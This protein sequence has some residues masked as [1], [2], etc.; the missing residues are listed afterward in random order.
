MSWDLMVV[1]F[2]G[3]MLYLPKKNEFARRLWMFKWM[4]TT[5]TNL[6][7]ERRVDVLMDKRSPRVFGFHPHGVHCVAA[8]LISTEPAT[9][10]IRVACTYF[11]FWV[12]V[13][14]EFCGW[15]NA[16]SCEGD[17]IKSNL[18]K[19]TP[20]IIYPGGINEVPGAHYM[21]EPEY[22][23]A[24]GGD[25][26]YYVY[27]RRRG[28]IR[29][30]MEQGV[31]IVPCWVD[32]EYDL[33]T[34]YHP[35]PRIQRWCYDHFRYPWPM[36]SIGWKWIP[37]LPKPRK[38]TVWVGDPIPTE[39]DGDVEEYHRA[40]YKALDDIIAEVKLYKSE[41]TIPIKQK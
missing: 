1:T 34:L 38:V 9:R 10:H 23:M 24:P 37:F 7:F 27:K 16:F 6:S 28:F 17:K 13:I 35:F 21:R 11:L 29:V 2:I 31:D 8:T 12:P 40:Y 25:E 39:P 30:A 15:G 41:G 18:R 3:Y 26:Q 36:V 19:G 32:G 5:M 22:D 14:K 33:Y 4:R 20:I